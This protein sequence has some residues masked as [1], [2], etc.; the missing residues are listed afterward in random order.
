[1]RLSLV[2]PAHPRRNVTTD[3]VDSA[4]RHLASRSQDAELIIVDPA[5]SDADAE[6]LQA[7]AREAPALRVLRDG[8]GGSGAAMRAGILAAGGDHVVTIDADLPYP[9]A[10]IDGILAA[11]DGGADLAVANRFAR[12]SRVLLS[13]QH[14]HAHYRQYL[15][16][17]AFN[18]IARM[19]LG[20]RA[21]DA[22]AGFKGWRRA[23]AQTVAARQTLDG[24]A[25][26]VELLFVAQRAG[27]SIRE[28]PVLHRPSA[29]QNGDESL[30]TL[31]RA[32]ADLWRIRRNQRLGRYR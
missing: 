13:S 21:S 28:V 27:L 10:E 15:G 8:G 9:L 14:I 22:L 5:A 31:S 24:I 26:H 19:L 6:R 29:E 18:A 1:M 25:A 11:L 17:R 4:L 2:I 23:A 30:G 12:E 16:H 3:G 20:L 32:V 7:L